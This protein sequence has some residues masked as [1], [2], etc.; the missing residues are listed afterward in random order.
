MSK[1]EETTPTESGPRPSLTARVVTSSIWV[2]AGRLASRGLQAIK[3]IV[4]ARLLA[5]TDLG[6]FGI[7]TLTLS[8]AESFTQ[9][10]FQTA[11]IQRRGN[12][13]EYLDTAW[14]VQVMR[15]LFLAG[16]LLAAAPLFARFFDEPRVIPLLRVLS[17]VEAVRGLG[18]IG[19]VYFRKE[20]EFHKQVAYEF[21]SSAVALAVVAGLA[22]H[23]RNVW[24][25]I[26]GTLV[27]Q[28]LK[29]TLSYLFHPYRPRFRFDRER[30]TGLFGFGKWVTDNSIV[31]FLA[32]QADRAILGRLLGAAA[33]GVYNV[34]DR[35]GGLVPT[36]FM[37][38][39]NDVMMPAYAKVQ[40]DKQRL[41]E[42][43]LE[44]FGATIS[45]GGPIAVFMILAGSNLVPVILGD[46]WLAAILPLQ[47]LAAG[48][49]L[50]CVIGVSSPVFLATGHP[51]IQFWKTL[52]RGLVTLGTVYPLTSRHGVAGTSVARVLG[53]A[54]LSPL[55]FLAIKIAG[56]PLRLLIKSALPGLAL[57]AMTAL[58]SVAGTLVSGD[59]LLALSAQ[60]AGSAL[61]TSGLL[62]LLGQHNLGPLVIAR[63][64]LR[65]LRVGSWI[66]PI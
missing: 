17:A 22:W 55:F 37:H 9:T 12:S 32:M 46:Q 48:A 44:V 29:T 49:F 28:S 13:E 36:E 8:A 3:M 38:L 6:L 52:I 39:T 43:F 20:L 23:F 26:W 61:L 31:S 60:V 18:N 5:P 15:G 33:L 10:G 56:V 41:G 25:L 34:A 63:R 45:V 62:V 51:H 14:T 35:I 30:A 57:T 50:R 11:L 54:A 21:I 19:V 65:H 53:V 1:H 40:D 66:L 7:V 2:F 42:A 64:Y 16:A 4:V 27:D 58:G 59:V 24:A 47:V